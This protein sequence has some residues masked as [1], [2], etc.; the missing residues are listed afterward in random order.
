MTFTI[1][2]R[3]IE[4]Y[5]PTPRCRKLRYREMRDT[6]EVSVASFIEQQ[7]HPVF[8]VTEYDIHLSGYITK[9]IYWYAD[10]LWK[11]VLKDRY[12]CGA[13]HEPATAE[14]LQ[15]VFDR[16][17]YHNQHGHLDAQ[18]IE[19]VRAVEHAKEYLFIDGALYEPCGEPMYNITTFGLGHNHGGTGF[20]VE[21]HYNPNISNRNYFNA[22]HRKE[23][24]EYA[25]RVAQNRGD[26]ESIPRL[27]NPRYN[28]EVLDSAAVH[29]DP[30]KDH[31]E[32]DSFLNMLDGLCAASDS[33]G[34]AAALVIC[35]TTSAM[36]KGE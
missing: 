16:Y 28:I 31:G 20:F 26:T 12:S 15:D 24:I 19:S 25:V 21:Y 13:P 30:M 14:D 7:A 4:A 11:V 23:A 5:L 18:E 17:R 29:R 36:K 35:T 9:T 22:L 10:R 33:V 8:R 27:Q 32:G 1:P 6:V 34:E 2:Y 3:Y